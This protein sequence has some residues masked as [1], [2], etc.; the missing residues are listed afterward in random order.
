MK[1]GRVVQNL[2]RLIWLI[3][4]ILGIAFWTGRSQSLTP[5]HECLGVGFVILL[6]ALGYLG[7]RSGASPGLV[8]GVLVWSFIVLGLGFAQTQIIP[9]SSHWI[10]R[11]LHVI[12]GFVAIGLAE[13]LGGR[14][15]RRLTDPLL[16][17]RSAIR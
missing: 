15:R 14:I 12:V 4:L 7:V 3:L 11:A 1:A 13:A 9:G 2:T 8:A 10:V 17:D 5:V 16:D 6:W